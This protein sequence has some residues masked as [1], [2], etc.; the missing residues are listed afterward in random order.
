MNTKIIEKKFPI[1]RFIGFFCLILSF[2]F[3][4]GNTA[5][6]ADSRVVENFLVDKTHDFYGRIDA[7]AFLVYESENAYLYFEKDYYGLMNSREKELMIA[8]IIKLGKEFDSV[9]YP[10]TKKVFGDEWSPGIDNDE[11]VTIFFTRMNY[12][13]GG[14]FNANDEYSKTQVVDDR[15]NEREMIYLNTDFLNQQKV[16]GFLSHELQHMIYWNEKTHVKGVIDDIWINEGRSELAA[17]LIENLLDKKSADKTL[18]VRKRDFLLG[19]DDSLVDWNNT[20]YDYATVNIFMQYIKDRVG[21]EIFRQLNGTRT[22]GV[23]N[24]DFIL[25]RDTDVGLNNVFTDW[26]IANYIN[27]TDFDAHYGYLD[28]NLKTN[29]NVVPN[30][31]NDVDGNGVIELTGTLS[32]WSTDYFEVR[33]DKEESDDLY[34][35][36]DFN[37][38]D[39]ST[40]SLPV[41]I[42]YRNGSKKVDILD[43]NS[44]QD[45]HME[46]VFARGNM[47]SVIFIP[48]CQKI[49][50][51]LD[52]NQAK[53]HT[54]SM[55]VSLTPVGKKFLPNGTLVKT[56]DDERIYLID[57]S[58]KRWITDSV[59]FVA[60]GYDWGDVMIVSKTALGIYWDGENI[61]N[62]N[63]LVLEGSLVK[64]S[65]PEIYLIE[66]GRR[67]W[68]KDERAFAYYGFDWS[69]VA[70]VNDQEFFQYAEGETLTTISFANG[71][72][73]KGA[74]EKVY[75]LQE[76]K[77]CWITSPEAFSKNN[78]NWS[79]VVETSEENISSYVDG[80]DI[81]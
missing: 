32:N 76:G 12:G 29:F 35:E 78:F 39:T 73:I 33:A 50:E 77:K 49:D 61:S 34:L 43:M 75:L 7:D 46:A 27:D 79:S 16:E 40:F 81:D 58:R 11:R 36:V 68:I 17:S 51:A 25:K 3:A 56:A 9:I 45:G 21:T 65:G 28:E 4:L 37:G 57:S 38:D 74:R 5:L 23:Y 71:V 66:D 60:R 13:V 6:A 59:T 64:G 52:G 53:K 2:F 14:Y 41:I 72:L 20:N 22:T 54:Y 69:E 18:S 31:I 62:G 10:E 24:L 48:S 26:T 8:N 19:Y 55:D 47:L 80:P 70:Q 30:P 1:M 42:N 67:R 44:S 15:S 63:G